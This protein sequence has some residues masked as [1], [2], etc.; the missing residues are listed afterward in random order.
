[1]AKKALITGGA[2]FIGF[3]L[4]KELTKSYEV[5]IADNFA[6]GKKDEEF[7]ELLEDKNVSFIKTD[8]T[9]QSD[10][11]KLDSYDF[12]YHLAAINGTENFYKI[13]DKVL[14]IGAIGTLN[15]LDWFVESKSKK[16]LFSSSSE[17]YSG[18][19]KVLK[20]FPIP[21]P[22]EIPLIVNDPRNVR[23]SYGA[24]KIL[25][26]VAVHSYAHV[27]KINFSIIRYHNI[28]GPR[29]GFEHVIPQFVE[30]IV[31]KEGPFKIYGGQE[32]R[33]FCYVEDAVN[34]T[35]LVMESEKA[36]RKTIHIGR[37]DGEIKIL[38]LAKSLF[39]IAKVNPEIKILPVPEGSV[40][41]RCPNT[42]K[43][44]ALGFKAE[45]SLEKGLENTFNWYRKE[46]ERGK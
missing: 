31:K 30:R 10:F 7:K 13:P 21:T 3:H 4:A 25:G 9:N 27:H 41:R 17:A 23:W 1:M 14:K 2:G 26:E 39:K 6:R 15:V 46:F 18:G 43:L 8:I 35:K 40:A 44:E 19:L 28:Y 33:T 24:G 37:K 32:T 20:D 11:S 45:T 22:E 38:D 29:M 16:L 12:V 36:D 34:A 5:T 42:S